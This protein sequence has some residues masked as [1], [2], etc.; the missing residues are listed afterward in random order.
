MSN[1]RNFCCL[2]TPSPV[3]GA[4]G[5]AAADDDDGELA[6]LLDVADSDFHYNHCWNADMLDKQ[7]H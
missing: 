7:L 6:V 4:A 2:R 1:E 3:C 5:D